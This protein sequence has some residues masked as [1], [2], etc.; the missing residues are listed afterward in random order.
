MESEFR[1]VTDPFK[2]L[3]QAIADHVARHPDSRIRDAAS[4]LRNAN[5]IFTVQ[6]TSTQAEFGTNGQYLVGLSCGDGEVFF[7]E[8]G[9]A[10]QQ[11]IRL[12][13]QLCRYNADLGVLN[14]RPSLPFIAVNP[15]RIGHVLGERSNMIFTIRDTN[16]AFA[17]FYADPHKTDM[18]SVLFD[19][20]LMQVRSGSQNLRRPAVTDSAKV[21]VLPFRSAMPT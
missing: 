7:I 19:R 14:D 5:A 1:Q 16:K 10:E 17:V 12:A 3:H 13:S 6:G 21:T 2:G 11:A 15:Q 8:A 18:D 4:A 20:R 9:R